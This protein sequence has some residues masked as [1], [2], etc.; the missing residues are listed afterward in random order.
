MDTDGK[1]RDY[2]IFPTTISSLSYHFPTKKEA[3]GKPM[4][5]IV[6]GQISNQPDHYFKTAFYFS[7]AGASGLRDN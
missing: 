7:K 1:H 5:S 6:F 3:I 4:A 2:L